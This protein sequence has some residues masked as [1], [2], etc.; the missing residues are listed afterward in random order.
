MGITVQTY[1]RSN[2]FIM[3]ALLHSFEHHV[4]GY[5]YVS[6]AVGARCVE[7]PFEYDKHDGYAMHVCRARTH[8]IVRRLMG[9]P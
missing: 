1:A 2:G 5:V 6:Y 3:R 8:V 4:C 9:R 7:R